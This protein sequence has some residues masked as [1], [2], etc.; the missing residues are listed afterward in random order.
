MITLQRFHDY[1]YLATSSNSS[2]FS[3]SAGETFSTRDYS[4][5]LPGFL[6]NKCSILSDSVVY[7]GLV[8]IM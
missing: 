2:Y 6:I 5:L 4:S 7:I 3:H 8:I 1:N